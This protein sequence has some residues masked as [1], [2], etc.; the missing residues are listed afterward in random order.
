MQFLT[1][2]PNF[3]TDEMSKVFQWQFTFDLNLNG[4]GSHPLWYSTTDFDHKLSDFRF[5]ENQLT[6]D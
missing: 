6:A 2:T 4:S 5:R 3:E 1:L